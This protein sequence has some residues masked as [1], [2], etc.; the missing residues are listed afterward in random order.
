MQI[1]AL[2]NHALFVK[3]E[4][5]TCLN[6]ALNTY[7]SLRKSVSPNDLMG[8]AVMKTAKSRLSKSVMVKKVNARRRRGKFLRSIN[9]SVRPLGGCAM[10][11]T[12]AHLASLGSVMR[13]FSKH[14]AM[15]PCGGKPKCKCS[16][17]SRHHPISIASSEIKKCANVA[18]Q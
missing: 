2:R 1:H 3:I 18:K 7:H 17:P 9:P 5:P 15:Y 12:H 14:I 16:R 6:L 4:Y 10:L 11:C 13:H 8:S